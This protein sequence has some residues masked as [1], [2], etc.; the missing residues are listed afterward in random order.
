MKETT[1]FVAHVSSF[2]GVEDVFLVLANQATISWLIDQLT[3]VACTTAQ[4]SCL[5]FVLGN[6]NPIESD[7]QCIVVADLHDDEDSP[8]LVQESQSTFRWRLSR[9]LA[10]RYRGLLS[11][12]LN[13]STPCHQYLE[14]DSGPSQA[15]I[16]S[17][18]EYDAETFRRK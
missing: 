7:G 6:G 16:V 18:G 14:L 15:V 10:D 8:Q 1:A 12:M 11:G 5:G 4:S 17:L 2:S 3:R 13:S 9:K